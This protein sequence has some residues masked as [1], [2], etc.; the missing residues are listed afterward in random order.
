MRKSVIQPEQFYSLN[1]IFRLGLYLKG[2]S[3]ATVY[4]HLLASI[5]D[6]RL[7]AERYRTAHRFGYRVKGQ[8]LKDFVKK[9]VDN[10][11]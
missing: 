1:E 5:A 7:N 10:P 4:R 11:Y 6:G 2:V 8:D 3:R 9:N